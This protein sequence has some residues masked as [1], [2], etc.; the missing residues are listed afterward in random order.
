[1]SAQSN[2]PQHIPL[3][4]DRYPLLWGIQ[5]TLALETLLRGEHAGDAVL[6]LFNLM[7]AA[8]T[9]D[10]FILSLRAR[11]DDAHTRLDDA[12]TRLDEAVT[13]AYETQQRTTIEL[14]TLRSVAGNAS[15][16]KSPAHPDPEVFDGATPKKLQQWLTDITVKLRANGDWYPSEQA[17][18]S[19]VFSRLSGKAKGQITGHVDD[20]GMFSFNALHEMIQILK[21][22]FGALNLQGEASSTILNL[23][24]GHKSLADFL[25]GWLELRALARFDD[26][27]SIAILKSALHSAIIDR[28]SYTAPADIRN[29]ITGF[30]AQVRE[31]DT[32]LRSLDPLYFKKTSTTNTTLPPTAAPALTTTQGGDAMD[33]NAAVVWTAKDVGRRPRT[34]AEKL[35]RR[36]YNLSHGL[37]TWC[38]LPTHI[39]PD[40]PSAPWNK[41]K[42]E[43]KPLSS[44][45]V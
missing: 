29:D 33:L 5:N 8:K 6:Q 40:C 4:Q 36:A 43:E 39:A 15:P 18:M 37:S 26:A 11:L 34:P 35:A 16:Q 3:S 12:H 24:Q 1:M 41:K 19:Y 42:A 9:N 13:T 45:N 22:S 27:A 21:Q 44:E 28:L 31:A 10:E 25:P 23:K 20:A 2:E 38:N 7:T 17:K 14:A 30:V 32:T